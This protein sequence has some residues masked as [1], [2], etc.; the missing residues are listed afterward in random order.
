MNFDKWWENCNTLECRRDLGFYYKLFKE[1]VRQLAREAGIEEH[2]S[3]E[4]DLHVST[5]MT[6]DFDTVVYVE[7]VN[8]LTEQA[9]FSKEVK[10]DG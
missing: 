2:M 3:N 8:N 7:W 4:Y 9:F 10:K 6:Y 1:D 5:E